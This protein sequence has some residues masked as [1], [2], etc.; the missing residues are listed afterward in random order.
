MS[1]G[2]KTCVACAEEIQAA[3]KLCRYCGTQQDDQ[4]FAGGESQQ[5]EVH[6]D[7][8][9][10]QA[11]II[12]DRRAVNPE[13]EK[14]QLPEA[15]SDVVS[16]A[17][18][19]FKLGC[20][21]WSSIAIV[22]IVLLSLIPGW[23]QAAEDRREEAAAEAEKAVADAFVD[24]A[25]LQCATA[26]SEWRG[27]SATSYPS[28]TFSARNGVVTIKGR[29][30]ADWV[31]QY[32]YSSLEDR[33]LELIQITWDSGSGDLVEVLTPNS[34][35]STTEKRIEISADCAA[36]F[37]AAAAIPLGQDNNAEVYATASACQTV[38]EWWMAVKKYPNAFGADRY[39][40][41]DLWIYL[42]TACGGAEGSAVCRDAETQG[43]FD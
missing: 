43:I 37:E 5:N 13:S 27:G 12:V 24:S 11:L 31:C 1:E 8:V 26:L 30:S 38:D 36:A 42:V 23:Q 21:G 10:D 18:P 20:F 28:S 41:E 29:S 6:P 15:K 16:E 4:R 25:E 33:N 19:P 9:D 39:P 34:Q 17:K 14:I 3:A 2:T 40:D 7:E 22:V 35:G 32:E